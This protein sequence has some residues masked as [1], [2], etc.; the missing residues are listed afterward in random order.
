MIIRN[1]STKEYLCKEAGRG[2]GPLPALTKF[3]LLGWSAIS[4]LIYTVAKSFVSFIIAAERPDERISLDYLSFFVKN[5]KRT[6]P[7]RYCGIC[8]FKDFC[9]AFL[10][11]RSSEA[12]F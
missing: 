9:F 11:L 6:A 2:A 10:K 1:V 12:S 8:L 3:L 7:Y 4:L 5:L